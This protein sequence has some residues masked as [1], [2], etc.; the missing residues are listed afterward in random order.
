MSYC[1]NIVHNV[2]M[3][4]VRVHKLYT[5]DEG[6][7]TEFTPLQLQSSLP[8]N[9]RVHSPNIFFLIFF[10]HTTAWREKSQWNPLERK[11]LSDQTLFMSLKDTFWAVL[12]FLRQISVKTK[13]VWWFRT[14]FLQKVLSQVLP[15]NCDLSLYRFPVT[16]PPPTPQKY[17][18]QSNQNQTEQSWQK[19]LY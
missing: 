19:L 9:Y 11:F 16:L 8:Y 1:W 12:F 18:T 15:S 5:N 7:H 6:A 14:G 2:S 10:L 13:S 3:I 17:C 4:P